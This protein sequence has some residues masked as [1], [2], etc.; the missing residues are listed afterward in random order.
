[1][2]DPEKKEE[3]GKLEFG[4]LFGSGTQRW[5]LGSHLAYKNVSK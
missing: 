2:F 5:R 1:M 3:L 4:G